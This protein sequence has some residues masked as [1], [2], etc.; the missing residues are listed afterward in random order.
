[1]EVS[2]E[3]SAFY[4]RYVGGMDASNSALYNWNAGGLESY[5]S[6]EDRSNLI[7]RPT[8]IF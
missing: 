8:L 2:Y 6:L 5:Y 4:N 1:M 3:Y 7:S